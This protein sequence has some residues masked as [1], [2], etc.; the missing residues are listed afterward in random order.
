MEEIKFTAIIIAAFI[1]LVLDLVWFHPKVFGAIWKQEVEVS[2]E[3]A[4][5]INRFLQYG[6]SLVLFLFISLLM[7]ITVNIGGPEGMRHGTEA[8][9]T[10]KHGA[11]HGLFMGILLVIPITVINGFKE[12]RNFSYLFVSGGYWILSL[13]LMGGILSAW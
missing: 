12:Q 2:P 10:F 1:P 6:L 3:V 5:K 9:S 4:K 11:F 8:F 7:S 13:A